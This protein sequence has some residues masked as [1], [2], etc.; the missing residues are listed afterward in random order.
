MLAQGV[1]NWVR[2]LARGVNRFPQR[3]VKVAVRASALHD[4]AWKSR[5]SAICTQRNGARRWS[6]LFT[7]AS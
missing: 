6:L 5:I 2:G 4:P 3:V 1:K 7:A